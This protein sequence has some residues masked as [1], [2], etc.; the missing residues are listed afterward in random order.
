[1]AVK[2]RLTARGI[3]AATASRRV[4]EKL[5]SALEKES[6]N[7]ITLTQETNNRLYWLYCSQPGKSSPALDLLTLDLLQH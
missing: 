6:F 3:T 2:V 5:T 1:M 4:S 7:T